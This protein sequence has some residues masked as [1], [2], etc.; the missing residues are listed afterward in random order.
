[1]GILDWKPTALV[2]GFQPVQAWLSS[3]R[4]LH[5]IEEILKLRQISFALA[6]DDNSYDYC[7]DDLGCDEP[8]QQLKK[9][10]QLRRLGFSGERRRLED[11]CC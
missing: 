6:F 1:M 11:L 8:S 5:T 2:L 10:P 4:R 7:R 3:S 9:T